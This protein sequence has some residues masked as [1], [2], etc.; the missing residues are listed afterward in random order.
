V[1]P[2]D[3][4]DEAL[5]G[6]LARPGRA[7]L[8]I[9]GTV[10]GIGS[11][12]ATL[13]VSRT[14]GNQIVGRFDELAA[15]EV[16][17][18]PTESSAALDQVIPWDA[19][20]RVAR[21]NGVV[22]V[23]TLSEVDVGESL[24]S[25]V[26][27][28]DPTAQTEFA[29]PVRAASPGALAAVRGTLRAGRWFDA[30]HSDRADAVVVLGRAAAERLG[31]PDVHEQRA[32]FVGDRIYVVIGILDSVGRRPE[33]LEAVVLPEGTAR[34]HWDLSAPGRVQIETDIGAAALIAEQAPLA[35]VPN[36]PALL[37]VSK[38]PEPRRVREGA[39]QDISGLFAVLGGV[40]L[41]VGAIGIAN[42]TLVSVLERVG[43]IGLRRALGARRRHIAL[44]FLAESTTMGILGGIL[45]TSAGALV[46]VGVAATRGWTPVLDPAFALLAPIAGGV[47][48]LL[49]GGY[50]ALRAAAL[51]PVD[52]L[53]AGT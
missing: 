26:P 33:L 17:L 23:G 13:G 36:Q 22:A 4:L 39:Q 16:T 49:A 3:L 28:I 46:V 6:L 7:V 27:V 37:A 9:L 51:E 42:V 18:E 43:E 25:A 20:Q 50:P 47:V 35:L 21:L 11:L 10:L 5:A 40:S 52:A 14:A 44:Q 12:V 45:G 24:V 53:R 32:V 19:E 1:N 38:P 2:R 30:G 8:T 34:A 15:T 31:I 48:G 29:M 41:L